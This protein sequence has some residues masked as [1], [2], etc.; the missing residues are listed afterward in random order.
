MPT[1]IV[2]ILDAENAEG[3]IRAAAELLKQGK[4]VVI[5]TETIYGAAGMLAIAQVRSR[6]LGLRLDT[7][8]GPFT[9]HLAAAAEGRRYLGEVGE[10]GN[11]M[12]QKLWPGPVTLVFEVPADRRQQAAGELGV[13]EG[14]LYDG[15]TISLR[16]PDNATASA[17]L[18]AAGPGVVA[19]RASV[20]NSEL[21]HRADLVARELGDKVD[22]ILDGGPT[23][24]SKAS[25]IIRLRG[26]SYDI[27]REGVYDRRIVERL[28]RTTILFICSGNT[29]RSPMAEGIARRLLSEK[30]KV[31]EG[32]LEKQGI[33]VISAG[34]MA[35]PGA[36][37]TPAAVAA[38]AGLGADLSRHRSRTLSVEL[39]HQ[40]DVIYTMCQSHAAAVTALVPSAAAKVST[41]A[42]GRDIEDPIGGDARLYQDLAV[43]LR[44]WIESRLNQ[45]HW[46]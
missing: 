10:L 4:V 41:L 40:S 15:S 38:A 30:L 28:L 34:S 46:P 45:R 6:L 42:P 11:R 14:D 22:L 8:G 39:I 16:C 21:A 20:G 9:V 37:A 1:P 32:E 44:Q 5:P 33:S 26:N 12:M 23:R 35:F 43:Q 3:E 25:T 7:A 2:S 19:V 27:V 36:K 24:Y 17:V 31:P 29:C 13:E 18:A